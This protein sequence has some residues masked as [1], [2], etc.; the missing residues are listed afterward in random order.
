MNKIDIIPKETLYKIILDTTFL[1]NNLN[2]EQIKLY[3]YILN[4]NY[5]NERIKEEF[6][7]YFNDNIENMNDLEYQDF[8]KTVLNPFLNEFIINYDIPYTSND[9]EYIINQILKEYNNQQKNK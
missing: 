9:E 8:I 5:F 4:K 1:N 3:L 6:Y 2:K 7:K